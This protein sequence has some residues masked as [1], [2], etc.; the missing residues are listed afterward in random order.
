MQLAL[1]EF[2]YILFSIEQL[3]HGSTPTSL[4]ELKDLKPFSDVQ[5]DIARSM[6][7]QIT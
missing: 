5:L 6:L 7:L 2:N 4:L 3:V 1:E